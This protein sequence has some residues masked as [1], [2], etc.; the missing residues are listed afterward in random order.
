MT[1]QHIR[2]G[3]DHLAVPSFIATHWHASPDTAAFISAAY[4]II[5]RFEANGAGYYLRICHPILHSIED[6]NATL[7]Y[8]QHLAENGAPVNVPVK[9]VNG[10]YIEPL[11]DDFYAQVVTEAPGEEIGLIHTDLRVYAAWG[12]SLGKL[13]RAA[14]SFQPPQ[15]TS[16][17]TVQRFWENVRETAM[18]QDEVLREAFLRVDTWLKT[19]SLEDDYGLCHGDYR[20]GNVIWDAENFLAV[21][22][23]FDE[24]NTHWFI[25]DVVRALLEFH[26]RP[27]AERQAYRKA[28]LRGYCE[29]RELDDEWLEKW[30]PQMTDFAQMRGLLMHL[31]T[32][33]E[34][35]ANGLPTNDARGRIWAVNRYEW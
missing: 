21:T 18:R 2:D 9:S 12:N 32:V 6:A 8:L 26:D 16:Y 11:K 20:P 30:V 31:W 29:A 28:F 15:G 14:A 34:D 4:N 33:Q 25:S 1:W 3:F 17:P 7:A 27:L 10:L 22:V 24:P 19:L 23:D 13:H 5:Y 35:E